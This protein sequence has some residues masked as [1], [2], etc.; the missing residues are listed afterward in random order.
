MLRSVGLLGPVR[1]PLSPRFD[2]GF[3]P[4]AGGQLRRSLAITAVDFH[5]LDHD[6]FAGHDQTS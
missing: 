1:R 5:Q 2:G 6:S 4:A 3:S